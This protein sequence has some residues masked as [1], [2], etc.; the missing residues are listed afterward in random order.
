MCVCVCVTFAAE[1]NCWSEIFTP[2]HTAVC[3]GGR[4]EAAKQTCLR[5]LRV[6]VCLSVCVYM[7]GC[8]YVSM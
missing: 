5:A 8:M 3:E 2:E 7:H 1:F 4:A 6:C